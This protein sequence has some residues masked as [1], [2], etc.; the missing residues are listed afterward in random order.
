VL[1]DD[2]VCTEVGAVD[3]GVDGP[4][5]LSISV[6]RHVAT[7]TAQS[8]VVG[9]V[10]VARLATGRPGWF[11]GSWWG[12]FAVGE[13]HVDVDYLEVNQGVRSSGATA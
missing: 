11:L 10:D 13:G 3:L 4:V 9:A 5:D 7:L 6:D 12:P 2:G 1:V 8:T